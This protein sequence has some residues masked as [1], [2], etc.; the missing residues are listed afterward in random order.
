MNVA[1]AARVAQTVGLVGVFAACA[2]FLFA[3]RRHWEFRDAFSRFVVALNA[4]VMLTAAG[5]VARRFGWGSTWLEVV[6]AALLV[7]LAAAMGAQL[8][9]LRRA[10]R[11]NGV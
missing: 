4:T 9:L 6:L 2:A 11:G 8:A 1:W 5:A 3:Y 7:G 10:H